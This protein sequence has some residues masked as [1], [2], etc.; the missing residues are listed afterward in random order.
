MISSGLMVCVLRWPDL[1]CSR[2]PTPVSYC[3]SASRVS[4]E[5]RVMHDT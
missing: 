4:L 3:E 5:S 2:F 1:L